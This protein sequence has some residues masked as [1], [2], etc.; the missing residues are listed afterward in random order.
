MNQLPVFLSGM[1]NESKVGGI[2]TDA[3]DS[4]N[5]L[6]V[7]WILE[8]TLLLGWLKKSIVGGNIFEGDNFSELTGINHETDISTGRSQIKLLSSRRKIN[9]SVKACTK[10]VKLRLNEINQESLQDKLSIF[11]NID[12]I[13]KLLGL[14]D[15]GKAILSYAVMLEAFTKFRQILA[16]TQQQSSTQQFVEIMSHLLSYS[17]A[18]IR[19]ELNADRGGPVRLNNFH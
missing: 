9:C 16:S 12:V 19:V 8:L 14:T 3:M 18:D 5:P 2:I 10:I 13:G 17:E 15:A 4:Y 1:N 11:K 6:L 7:R